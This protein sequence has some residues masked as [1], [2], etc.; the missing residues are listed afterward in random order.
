MGKLLHFHFYCFKF[1]EFHET[2][3]LRMSQCSPTLIFRFF[4]NWVQPWDNVRHCLSNALEVTNVWLFHLSPASQ[5]LNVLWTSY[6]APRLITMRFSRVAGQSRHRYGHSG[7][8]P[9]T[10]WD[11]WEKLSDLKQTGDFIR[12]TRGESHQEIPFRT[13]ATSSGTSSVVTTWKRLPLPSDFRTIRPL[14]REITFCQL[15]TNYKS[16]HI[17]MRWK[18]R[19]P[20]GYPTFQAFR[21]LW[22]ELAALP[23]HWCH[24]MLQQKCVVRP[25][26]VLTCLRPQWRMHIC[27][28]G[29]HANFDGA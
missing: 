10:F 17:R 2:N 4:L 3:L 11:S 23:P 29:V 1:R 28:H 6:N 20:F 7:Y 18:F 16:V 27:R 26:I 12:A 14:D 13:S 5:K 24:H 22:L 8:K 21:F 9:D 19:W 15:G 25:W